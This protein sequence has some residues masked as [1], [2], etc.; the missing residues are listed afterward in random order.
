MSPH[1]V[2]HLVRHAMQEKK[3]PKFA[4]LVLVVV[5][6]FLAP[7]LIGIPIVLMGIYKLTR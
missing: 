1:H 5:G 6:L 2:S 4:G 3:H 7:W